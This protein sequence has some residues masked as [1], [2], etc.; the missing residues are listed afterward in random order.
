MA[1][2]RKILASCGNE[3]FRKIQ[4]KALLRMHNACTMS[5]MLTNCETWVLN[6]G[7]REKLERIE[8]WALKKILDVPKTTPT[9][10]VWYITGS[11]TT[12]ILIDKR[13]LL[14]LKTIL[15]RPEQDPTRQMLNCMEGDDIGWANQIDKK[16]EKYNIS[17]SWNEIRNMKFSQWKRLVTM[18]TEK[19]NKE[20]LINMCYNGE[21]E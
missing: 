4:L 18:S 17:Y 9:P 12:S 7:E 11:L 15:D 20:K 19:M 8:L 5:T 2:T 13:Q 6:K 10:A 16:L 1:S 3:V 21:I 14:Y